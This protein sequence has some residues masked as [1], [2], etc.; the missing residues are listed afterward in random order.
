MDNDVKVWLYDI[1]NAVMEID[2]Y[3]SDRPKEFTTF[4]NDLRTRRSVE[5]NIE[6]IGE[7]LN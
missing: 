2:S 1:L 3:F 4:K 6:I 5:R 7:A